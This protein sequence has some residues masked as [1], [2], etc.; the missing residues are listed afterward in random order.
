MPKHPGKKVTKIAASV[1]ADPLQFISSKSP[2]KVR[3]KKKAKTSIASRKVMNDLREFA[4]T[5]KGKTFNRG[6][7]TEEAIRKRLKRLTR[8]LNES[9]GK[10]GLPLIGQDF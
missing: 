2:G 10:D 6:T 9:L 4:R 5:G 8:E 7:A 3:K 1:A